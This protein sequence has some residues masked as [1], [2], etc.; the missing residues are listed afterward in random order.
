VQLTGQ[1]SNRGLRAAVLDVAA[2]VTP[3]LGFDPA[4]RFAGLLEGTIADSIA[5]DLLAVV[6][7]AL[8]NVARHAEASSV[9]VE[10][11]A[12]AG[13]LTLD[14]RDDGVGLDRALAGAGWRT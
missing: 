14:V 7:E 11:T 2:E 13:S 6:R 8:S 3:A 5:D 9:E 1:A 12:Q 10:V 4:V